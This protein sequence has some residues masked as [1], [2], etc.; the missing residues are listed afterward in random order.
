MRF[1]GWKGKSWFLLTEFFYCL[2]KCGRIP[3][4]L[5]YD[6]M[7][8]T[9]DSAAQSGE[10][11]SRL[12]ESSNDVRRL[13]YVWSGATRTWSFGG[14]EII[15]LLF[16]VFKAAFLPALRASLRQ[17]RP[18]PGPDGPGYYLSALRA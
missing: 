3:L 1:T 11:H 9:A 10:G 18:H 6:Q 8:R 5:S 16:A 13:E 15:P 17:D 2:R 14:L 12:V 4:I 7:T